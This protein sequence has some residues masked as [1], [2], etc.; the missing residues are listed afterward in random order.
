MD[1]VTDWLASISLPEYSKLCDFVAFSVFE[2]VCL[3]FPFLDFF[4]ILENFS[5]KVLCSYRSST[6]WKCKRP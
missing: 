6:E 4:A 5:E 1:C 3:L 2:L